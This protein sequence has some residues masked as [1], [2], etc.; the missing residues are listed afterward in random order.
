MG[1]HHLDHYNIEVV[2]LEETI[3]FYVEVL[4]LYVGERPPLPFPGAWLYCENDQ[5]T[6]HLIGTE[7][8]EPNREKIPS[9]RLHHI[10]F[11]TTGLEEVRARLVKHNIKFNTVVLPRVHNTQFFMQDPNGINVELNFPAEETRP[12]DLEMMK[13]KG[14]EQFLAVPGEVQRAS[15]APAS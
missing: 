15:T 13:N 2:N 9:G 8:G 7:Q 11:Q 4:G 6:I 10:C 1:L 12:E 3:K 14:K 5:P